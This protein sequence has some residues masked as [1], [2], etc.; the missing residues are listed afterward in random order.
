MG[1]SGVLG[2]KRRMLDGL[3]AFADRLERQDAI[4]REAPLDPLLAAV[5]EHLDVKHAD[6]RN[7][8]TFVDAFQFLA[9]C[10]AEDRRPTIRS[11][12]R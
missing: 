12:R 6:R 3:S 5:F 4:G 2:L 1:S 7:R 8:V 10:V 9:R 11:P